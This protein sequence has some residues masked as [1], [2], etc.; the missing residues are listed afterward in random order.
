MQCVSQADDDGNVEET[1]VED[2]G[3]RIPDVGHTQE[4]ENDGDQ[5]QLCQYPRQVGPQ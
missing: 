2:K 1:D 5:T 3:K 4:D